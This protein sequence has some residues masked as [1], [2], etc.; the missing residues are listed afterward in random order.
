L[1]GL[2]G[3]PRIVGPRPLLP[4]RLTQYHWALAQLCPLVVEVMML[5]D[6][7]RGLAKV[8]SDYRWKVGNSLDRLGCWLLVNAPTVGKLYAGLWSRGRPRLERYPGWTF[9][10]EY[11]IERRWTALRRAALWDF[12]LERKLRVPLRVPW[13]AGTTV[14]VTLGNDQS[15]CLYVSGSF[16]P[17]EFAFIDRV[18]APG[19]TVVDVGANDGLYTVFAARRVGP[20]GR[21]LAVEPSS[22]ERANLARNVERNKLSNVTVWP[23]ALGAVA[24]QANLKIAHGLHAG[25]NTFGTFAYDDVLAVDSELVAVETLDDVVQ[26]RALE[27]VDFIKVDVEGAEVGVLQG[28][29]QVLMSSRPL[30]LIEANEPALQAQ[31]TSVQELLTLLRS[32]FRYDIL[33]FS[34][35]TGGVEVMKDGAAV[36]PNIVAVPTERTPDIL[37]KAA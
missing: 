30:L 8:W 3:G 21:V 18:L 24:G 29:R 23:S 33:V 11:F 12:A 37:A 7:P 26:R 35:H 1:L 34:A 20:S 5:A 16:E 4:P 14:D 6:P 32:E 17:N 15:L 2:L 31:G 13:Y 19:M 27:H 22:R 9:A 10:A 36:S 25:H 28:A